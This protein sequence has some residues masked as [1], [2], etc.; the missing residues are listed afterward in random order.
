MALS[1]AL[2]CCQRIFSWIPV[3]IISSVVLWS[4]YAY[5]FEL[6]F[7]K[8]SQLIHFI[9]ANACSAVIRK[10]HVLLSCL[11]LDTKPHLSEAEARRQ[12]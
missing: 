11:L 8:T 6:C 3:I 2:R 5:V 1:R 12:V 7:G 4:Y 10:Y 9:R